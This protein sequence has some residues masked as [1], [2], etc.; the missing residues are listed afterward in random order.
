M[1]VE[2]K[3]GWGE[4]YWDHL[5]GLEYQ[6]REKRV[7]L[8]EWWGSSHTEKLHGTKQLQWQK[9]LSVFKGV[10]PGLNIRFRNRLFNNTG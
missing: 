9:C 10:S 6:R 1:A 4:D 7:G 5:E 2:N 3:T 8:E